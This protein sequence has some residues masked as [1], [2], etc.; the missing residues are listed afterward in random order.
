[1]QTIYKEGEQKCKT[2]NESINMNKIELALSADTIQKLGELINKR[3]RE[4]NA[5]RRIY[6][7]NTQ[8]KAKAS[9]P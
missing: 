5:V 1:M 8:Y 7:A 3:K 6:N 9:Q 4:R 2:H